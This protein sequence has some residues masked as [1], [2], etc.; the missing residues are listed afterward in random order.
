MIRI[1]AFQSLAYHKTRSALTIAAMGL[2]TALLASTFGFQT[3]YRA[4]LKRNIDAMGY[5]ILVTGKG[6]PHEAATLILRGGSIPMYI[7]EEVYQ[8]IRGR[9][10]VQDATR[11]FMQSVPVVETGSHQLYVGIDESFIRLKP[12]VTFQRGEWFSSPI[13]NEAILGFNV[14]EYHR[15]GLGDVIEVGVRPFEIRGVLDKLGTQDD[16]TIFLPLEVAQEIFEKRDLLTGIGIRLHDIDQAGPFIDR[17][18]E[19]PS[20]QVV[21][22]SSV[23]NMV[24]NILR[25]VRGL[26]MAFGLLCLVVALMGVFNVALMAVHERRL[27]LGVLRAMGCP[28][29]MLFKMVWSE[30]LLL[31]A[32]GALAGA[33]LTVLLRGAVESAFRATLTFVPS[34]VVVAVTPAG[35]IGSCGLVVLL[36]LVAGIYP[37]WRS[38]V[39]P[40]MASIR[41]AA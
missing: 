30:V 27:E 18:Y 29:S 1:W 10:E 38:S 33:V 23:Q 37:A 3:G 32:F 20:I 12:G 31:T 15:L 14:A 4:A 2:A 16:G 39:V 5:Q 17:L 36:G 25:G 6:C 26:L 24:L 40:P 13:A 35:L 41:G 8:H 7:Q 28:A 19:I 22:M 11:F 9:S 21:R 34:G